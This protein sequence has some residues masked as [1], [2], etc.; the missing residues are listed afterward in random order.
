MPESAR[1]AC[2]CRPAC[3]TRS[4]ARLQ[5]RRDLLL[6]HHL[7]DEGVLADA[8]DVERQRVRHLHAQRRGVDDE[9]E[10]GGIIRARGDFHLR[11]VLPKA[12]RRAPRRTRLRMSK[13]AMRATPS[14]ASE[15][16]MPEPT[17]P[18]PDDQARASLDV[19]AL[20]LETASEAG[21][22]EHVADQLA[23]VP[24]EHRVARTGDLHGGR[25]LVEQEPPS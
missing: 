13:S 17:P 9:I 6:H 8:R 21:A 1:T 19:E 4:R 23:V 24:Q 5:E 15:A 3:G 20:A 14:A 25:C 2:R 18:V 22:V 7:A 12:L 11:I 10:P 16:A